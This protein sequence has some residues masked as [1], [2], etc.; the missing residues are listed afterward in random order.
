[1]EWEVMLSGDTVDEVLAELD[2]IILRT[3]HSGSRAIS[4]LQ[5]SGRRYQLASQGVN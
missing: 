3:K 2:N 4:I 5:Q 1:M